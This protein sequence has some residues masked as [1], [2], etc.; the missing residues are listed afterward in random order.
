M[1]KTDSFE[2]LYEEL[3][4]TVYEYLLK[5]CGDHSVAE[6]IAQDTFFKVFRSIGSYRGDCKFS[7][8][9]CAIARN[10]YISYVRKNKRLTELSENIPAEESPIP[11]LIAEKELSQKVREALLDLPEPYREVFR[12]R[13]F[14]ELSFARIAQRCKKTE[15][16][17]RVT[18]HRAKLKIREEIEE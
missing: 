18:Y 9:V 5:L 12:M 17:A 13:V 4:P 6:E 1:K 3:Y 14:E 8:W 15:S 10:G 7:T 11:D 2:K 16:W